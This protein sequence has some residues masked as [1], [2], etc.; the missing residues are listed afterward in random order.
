[1]TSRTDTAGHTKVFDYLVMG[2]WGESR[3]VQIREW[4]NTSAHT[5]TKAGER[6]RER[7]REGEKEKD[8]QT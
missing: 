2:H 8:I 7:D 4:D 5:R 6:D 1:M 3:S